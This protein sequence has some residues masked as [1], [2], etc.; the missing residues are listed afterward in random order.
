MGFSID[1]ESPRSLSGEHWETCNYEVTPLQED[2]F[3]MCSPNTAL[4]SRMAG[5]Y[6]VTQIS[7]FTYEGGQPSSGSSLPPTRVTSQ[8]LLNSLSERDPAPDGVFLGDM[9][10]IRG[11][12]NM[13]A[14]W[15]S[16]E[17]PV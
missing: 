6:C 4:D 9:Y 10:G 7:H 15:A 11:P 16:S 8:A 2:N 13:L 5:A 17:G 12:T 1:Q 14:S 3:V